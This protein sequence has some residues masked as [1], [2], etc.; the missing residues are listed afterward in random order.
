MTDAASDFRTEA[1]AFLAAHPG[2]TS[3][4]VLFSDIS[5]IF[6]GKQ[7]PA[8]ELKAL[9][10]KGVVSPASHLLLDAIGH[11]EHPRLGPAFSGDPDCSYRP[12]AGT[13]AAVPWRDEPTA[14]VITEAYSLDGE[15]HFC[16][17]RAILRKALSPITAM[18]L[19]PVVALELEFHLFD[20]KTAR[21]TPFSLAEAPPRLTGTQCMSMEV[22]DD[23]RPFLAATKATCQA[24]G[25]PLSSILT[26][27][28]DG[29]FEGNLRHVPD[30]VLACDHAMLLKRA[31]KA[32]ARRQ[33][34]MAS[35]M[36]KP[37]EGGTGSGLHVHMSLLDKSGRNVFAGGPKSE[38]LRH[39][40]GGML[41]LMPES[42]L[43]FCPNANSYRRLEEG[44]FVPLEP[45]WADNERGTAIRLPVAGDKDARFE[46]R[47]AG[48][49]ACPYLTVAAILAGVHHGLTHRIDP[50]PM[51]READTAR[52]AKL[53]NRWPLAIRALETAEVLPRY[54][55]T[56][57]VDVYLRMK[58]FEE[59]RYHRQIPDRDLA[60]YLR[61][62]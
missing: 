4:E 32:L 41:A 58:R 17:P 6:R 9:A 37:I 19:T 59:E 62:V 49:D 25:I 57:F 13:L 54:I 61:T 21:P 12:V 14:Q 18:G 60:W 43:L 45:C 51:T 48:A 24:Q 33:G 22:M 20:P 28:G 55:G 38:A 1:E 46:H 23:Y 29:Q 44:S 2:L 47:V 31:V 56:D 8:S 39:A 40:I 11:T 3:L 42:M 35:F 30:A 15:P 5:G 16:D 27:F 7:Y 34:G 10:D 53:P 26:E 50:G 52:P 36:A